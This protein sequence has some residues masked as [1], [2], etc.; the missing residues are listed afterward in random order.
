MVGQVFVSVGGDDVTAELG[1]ITIDSIVEPD[2]RVNNL[3]A[4]IVSSDGIADEEMTIDVTIT[5][6]QD[7]P[8]V[9]LSYNIQAIHGR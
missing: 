6:L 1:T 8:P 5:D 9:H 2:D 4:D 7:N 3:V